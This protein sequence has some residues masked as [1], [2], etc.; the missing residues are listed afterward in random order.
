MP[1]SG[2]FTIFDTTNQSVFINQSV[3]NPHL[4]G[5]NIYIWALIASAAILFTTLAFWAKIRNEDG[6]VNPT[7]IAF[8]ILGTL[9][10]A[11]SSWFSIELVIPAG[12]G[13]STYLNQTVSICQSTIVEGGPLPYLFMISGIFCF[14]NGVYCNILPDMVKPEAREFDGP[15]GAKVRAEESRGGRRKDA[16]GEENEED[17]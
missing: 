7:R 14:V 5:T 6:E 11:F 15:V 16:I 1:N 9:F 13:V 2:I 12:C 17:E 10:C 4:A 8:C 3:I